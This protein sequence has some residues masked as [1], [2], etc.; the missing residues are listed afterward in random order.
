MKIITRILFVLLLQ[1]AVAAA[2]MAQQP[3]TKVSLGIKPDYFYH[4]KGK[5]VKVGGVIAGKAAALAGIK[6]GDIIVS[7]DDK[8]IETI[9][10]YRDMLQTYN[11]GDKVK[12]TLTRKGQTIT[13]SAVFQ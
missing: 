9:Y 11:K 13:T 12:V 7:M 10:V 2:A 5:G 6:E 4:F 8:P 1:L 3:E